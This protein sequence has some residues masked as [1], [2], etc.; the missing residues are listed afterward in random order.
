MREPASDSL[1][2]SEPRFRAVAFLDEVLGTPDLLIDFARVF[3]GRRDAELVVHPPAF[4][5]AESYLA[6]EIANFY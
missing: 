3:A 1:P 6:N 2:P 5:G 4:V